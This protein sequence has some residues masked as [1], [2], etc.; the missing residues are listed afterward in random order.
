MDIVAT[1]SMRKRTKYN[2]E[3]LC[4]QWAISLQAAKD[5]IKVTT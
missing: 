3:D 2:A 4:K 5:T 1:E